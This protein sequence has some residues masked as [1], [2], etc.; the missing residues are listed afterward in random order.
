MHSDKVT[1]VRLVSGH[2]KI[3]PYLRRA[4]TDELKALSV[5]SPDVGV[6]FS[7]ANSQKGYATYYAVN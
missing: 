3:A 1:F 5:V 2:A 6:S 4:D 7:I